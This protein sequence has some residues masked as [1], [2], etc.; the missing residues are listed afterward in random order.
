MESKVSHYRSNLR[1]LQFNLFEVFGMDDRLGRPPFDEIDPGTARE[2]LAQVEQLAVGPVAESFTDG[3]RNPPVYDPATYSVTM[4]ESF[5]R[6]YQAYMDAEWWRLDLPVEVG[7]T[8]APRAL[9][10]AIVELIQGA[11][12]PV[13]MVGS[14]PSFGGLLHRLGTPE[15]ARI[16]RFLVARR[17]GGSMVPTEPAAGSAAGAGR[18]KAVRQA[19]G[20]WHIEGVKR[21]IT[22]AE[23]DLADNIIHLVLARPEGA[24]AG[25][26]GLSL[27]VVPKFHVDLETGELGERNGAYVTNV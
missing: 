24:K 13:Y 17:W 7:G 1:D 3:D 8:P 21:F 4:P 16:G 15:Q 23:H 2:I 11:H 5:K 19:D 20:T 9:W 18:T 12:A 26:K 14:G 25:T 27:F 22:S 10:W 6:S